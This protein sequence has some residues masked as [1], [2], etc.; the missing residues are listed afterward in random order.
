MWW[1]AFSR[2]VLHLLHCASIIVISVVRTILP[3]SIVCK[4]ITC[5]TRLRLISSSEFRF[6]F[7]QN[8]CRN[9]L[10]PNIPWS[11]HSIDITRHIHILVCNICNPIWTQ[12]YVIIIAIYILY[13]SIIRMFDKSLRESSYFHLFSALFFGLCFISIWFWLYLFDIVDIPLR[14]ICEQYF[15]DYMIAVSF[16]EL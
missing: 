1:P 2:H 5:L 4:Q 12:L 13:F 14:Y 7:Q 9:F 8:L 16:T 15:C 10:N 11:N 3:K 6:Y